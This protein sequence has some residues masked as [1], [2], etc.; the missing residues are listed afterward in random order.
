LPNGHRLL[1]C[2][3]EKRARKDAWNRQKSLDKLQ[4]KRNKSK[5]PESF[6]QNTSY[7]KYLKIEQLSQQSVII[8]EEKISRAAQWNGLHG[9]ITNITDITANDALEHYRGVWQIKDILFDQA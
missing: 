8:D 5:N 9:I 6:L 4:K 3:S 7:R 1:V 2:Y